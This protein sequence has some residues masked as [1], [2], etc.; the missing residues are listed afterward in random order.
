MERIFSIVKGLSRLMYWVSSVALISIVFL[1]VTDVILRRFKMPIDW[2][3]EVVILLGAITIGFSI[4][5]TTLNKG[6]VLMEFFT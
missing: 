2:A 1:T 3:Y 5:Q 6:H 4:P